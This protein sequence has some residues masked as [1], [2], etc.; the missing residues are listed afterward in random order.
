MKRWC[1]LLLLFV[2]TSFLCGY[3]PPE[4]RQ[5]VDY[6]L[7]L[8]AADLFRTKAF[9][10]DSCWAFVS[11]RQLERVEMS[12]T[13]SRVLSTNNARKLLV[14]VVKQLLAK[15]NSDSLLKERRLVTI[16][17][18]AGQVY[19][20][21]KTDNI[22]SANAATNT[23]RRMLLNDGVITYQSYSASTLF[24]GP[25]Y[26]FQ[27]TYEM[28]LM[29]LDEPVEFEPGRETGTSTLCSPQMKKEP[30]K[31]EL[32]AACPEIDIEMPSKRQ[33]SPPEESVLGKPNGKSTSITFDQVNN[34]ELPPDAPVKEVSP[35]SNDVCDAHLDDHTGHLSEQEPENVTPSEEEPVKKETPT[36]QMAP[37]PSF[38]GRMKPEATVPSSEK[39]EESLS[40][41]KLKEQEKPVEDIAPAPSFDER[42]KPEV[43]VPS[44]EKVEE[45]IPV[46]KLDEQR[47]HF[48]G[49]LFGESRSKDLVAEEKPAEAEQSTG[50]RWYTIEKRD[51]N[52]ES[53]IVTEEIV[54]ESKGPSWWKITPRS[55]ALPEEKPA[56][57]EQSTGKSW[58]TIEKR[59]LNA[60]S[61]FVTE[62]V[63]EESKPTW[64]N[65]TPRSQEFS[66]EKSAEAEQSTEKP[67]YTVEN[68]DLNTREDSSKEEFVQESSWLK[69]LPRQ[70]DMSPEESP[71]VPQETNW[72]GWLYV[73]DR[74]Q[75]QEPAPA[76]E[77]TG[78]WWKIVQRE[79]PAEEEAAEP[80]DAKQSDTSQEKISWLRV[81]PREKEVAAKESVTEPQDN[82]EPA[83]AK[84]ETG[85]W[86]KAVQ[87]EA[88][89]EEKAEEPSDTK[90]SDTTQEKISWLRVSPREKEV[91]AKESVT[92][93]QDNRE[94]APAK[95]ETGSWW[96][97]VQREAPT[98]E[99]AEE[100]SEKPKDDGTSWFKVS[101]RKIEDTKNQKEETGSSQSQETPSKT[102][103]TLNKL[104]GAVTGTSSL[105][106]DDEDFE[107]DDVDDD[108]T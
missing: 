91:A 22:F 79:A 16:P 61:P 77:E 58:Y 11:T 34:L 96:K 73:E 49:W 80:S 71:T 6:F 101:P 36:Q 67:L 64:W 28:A 23:V 51:P 63:V 33:L 104:W 8:Q 84:E 83:P 72:N 108:E 9:T 47:T 99:K 65:V 10:L 100:S 90:Q 44:S 43:T 29:L 45:S 31:T 59:D 66:E 54:E 74:K 26:T 62:E 52:A 82:Q 105:G 18:T 86:W 35:Q 48:F 20:E 17:F 56:E 97:A 70:K 50:K 13:C 57:A 27:E 60:E 98:E 12:F 42:L 1:G 7:K 4:D 30:S 88:P 95:E 102:P 76:K 40:V 78:S 15:I 68:R 41:G 3:V 69:V 32:A 107:E 106:D 24:C 94:P 39:V 103:S 19:L 25:S 21:I 89:A 14:S 87:R 5:Y 85:S 2:G 75:D 93:P 81:S 92:E 37:A 46:G 38:D 55:Q 53:P